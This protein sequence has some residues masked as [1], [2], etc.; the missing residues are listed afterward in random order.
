MAAT[1]L[2]LGSYL[3]YPIIILLILSFNTA[4]DILAGPAT[5]GFSNWANAWAQPRL[6]P[7]L[8]NSFL[9]WFLVTAIAFPVA[10]AISLTLARTRLPFSHGL[11]FLF[12]VAFI[13]PNLSTTLGWIMLLSPGWGFLNQAAE[14]LHVVD[15]G[16]FNIFSL[17]GIVWARLMGDGIAFKVIL[18]T[19]AFRNMNGALEEAG[20]VSGRSGLGTMLRI[21]LPVMISPIVLVLALQLIRVFQGFETEWL[22]GARWGF[23]VY[24]TLIYQLVRLETIPRYADAVVLA[25]ITLLMI[26]LVIPL[27]HWILHRRTYTTVAGSFRP[28]LI[29]LGRWRWVA[30]GMIVGVIFLLTAMPTLVLVV[31]SFMARVGFFETTP[32]WT[33]RH[34][35]FVLG[36]PSFVEAVRT[37]LILAITAGIAS[38]ILF[39]FLAYMIVRTRWRGGAVLDAMIW[40][41][42]AMP[43]IL[44][45]LGLLL[46]FLGTPGLKWIFGTIWPLVIV[47]TVAGITT[48]TNVFKGVL[49]QL[50]KDL[51]EAGRVAGA[52]WLRTYVSIVIPVLMPVMV[53]IGT[54]N[55]VSAAGAT[56]SLILLASRETKT[57]SIVALE[58]GSAG[59]GRLE[60]AGIISLII[61]LLTLS[62][63]LPVRMIAL[64]QGVRHDLH[65]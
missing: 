62:I 65:A 58:Y 37:T 34:W 64:R 28:G 4:R 2:V 10:I 42:A 38:P 30:F 26:A 17:P 44:L 56:S 54:L 25:S 19:P 60:E 22:L 53:L 36:D 27:Q 11:E 40:G 3:L 51:E 49:I 59:G 20:R 47:V 32:L 21:T 29:N 1:I 45:G 50:G 35:Q 55:F 39:S 23:F 12:W 24:S 6:L 48:G 15:K 8:W 31:G 14:A 63:A 41:S 13:L 61:T 7:S 18:L 5:W 46:M 33:L 52:G 43:G 9:V 57:L 16:P